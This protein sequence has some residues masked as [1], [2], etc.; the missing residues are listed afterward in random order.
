MSTALEN[1]DYFVEL[2]WNNECVMRAKCSA[3]QAY[4]IA[5]SLFCDN[6]DA[7]TAVAAG[8]KQSFPSSDDI[9]TLGVG[10]SISNSISG[11]TLTGGTGV[12]TFLIERISDRSAA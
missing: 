2:H 11:E 5:R 1:L 8:A 7:D 12:A 6:F 4:N 3:E 10:H 9:N